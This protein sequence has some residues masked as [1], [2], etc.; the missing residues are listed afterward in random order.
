MKNRNEKFVFKISIILP[1]ISLYF[2]DQRL[3]W[4][5]TANKYT[6]INNKPEQ[7]AIFVHQR[8]DGQI[9]AVIHLLK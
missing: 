1:T 8:I 5:S 7:K 9:N 3:T 2:E 6:S 4:S